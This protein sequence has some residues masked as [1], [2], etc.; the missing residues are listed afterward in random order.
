[1]CLPESV[2]EV[3]NLPK[4]I[5][6][7][8]RQYLREVQANVAARK[9]YD[10]YLAGNISKNASDDTNDFAKSSPTRLEVHLRLLQMRKRHEELRIT[11]HYLDKLRE[12]DPA[13]NGHLHLKT[14]QNGEVHVQELVIPSSEPENEFASGAS[15]QALTR[16]LE[17][18]V[19]RAKHQLEKE[20]Q[21]LADIKAQREPEAPSGLGGQTSRL[22]ALSATR[23]ELVRWLDEKLSQAGT[24]DGTV[25]PKDAIENAEDP[26]DYARMY[27]QIQAQYE[28]YIEARKKLLSVAAIATSTSIPPQSQETTVNINAESSKT[29]SNMLAQP[30]FSTLPF[31]SEQ[32]LP[33]LQ[34]Q[35]S[36]ALQRSYATRLLTTEKSAA[37]ESL[38]WLADESHLLPAYPI[39]ARQERFRHA[40]AL[41][42]PRKLERAMTDDEL[43]EPVRRVEAWAFA[44]KEA[45]SARE[46][47]VGERVGY[48]SERLEGAE[49][50]LAELSALLRRTSSEEESRQRGERDADEDVWLEEV[51]AQG[52]KPR[53]ARQGQR[54]KGPWAGLNGKLGVED[55]T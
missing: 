12:T 22:L 16:E 33:L 25:D 27:E 18:A 47:F 26:V 55:H 21:L 13:K 3:K 23:D 14:H 50:N 7:I 37:L 36:S 51:G 11:R 4:E 17:M 48:S 46:E 34:A 45:S 15:T 41:M 49:N 8:R 52:P 2:I 39:M 54:E 24:E 28:K 10:G 30:T 38:E 6:G 31:I 29:T 53:R 9:R 35:K 43:D 40:A 44:A 5:V 20:K 32:L 1:M 42:G 19:I